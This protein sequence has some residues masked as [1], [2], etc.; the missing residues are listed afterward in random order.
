MG[1]W[2]G[3]GV[4]ITQGRKKWP[5]LPWPVDLSEPASHLSMKPCCRLLAPSRNV[6]PG[7]LP[8]GFPGALTQGSH[9]AATGRLPRSIDPGQLPSSIGKGQ[10][11][12]SYLVTSANA[13]MLVSLAV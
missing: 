8:G 6:E 13:D 4:S 1:H 2:S 11:P 12:S 7:Q 9:P 5:L 10:L 3:G